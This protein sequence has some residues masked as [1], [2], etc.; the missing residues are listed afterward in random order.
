[1]NAFVASQQ[2]TGGTDLEC[3]FYY[4]SLNKCLRFP[5]RTELPRASTLQLYLAAHCVEEKPGAHRS[6]LL[7]AV[8][9]LTS[10]RDRLLPL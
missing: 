1:M 9:R 7:E 10:E 8:L 6:R 2:A 4:C 3:G 5:E